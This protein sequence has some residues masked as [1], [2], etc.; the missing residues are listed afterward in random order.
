MPRP[1]LRRCWGRAGEAGAGEAPEVRGRRLRAQAGAPCQLP[2]RPRLRTTRLAPC[3]RHARGSSPVPGA[4]RALAGRARTRAGGERARRRRGRRGAAR[5]LSLVLTARLLRPRL[6]DLL[7]RPGGRLPQ[8]P[9][10]RPA[11]LR[12]LFPCFPGAPRFH[13]VGI[14]SQTEATAAGQ[15]CELGTSPFLWATQVLTF[16]MGPSSACEVGLRMEFNEGWG[17]GTP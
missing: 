14:W 12:L 3:E 17:P 4:G 11:G 8:A 1:R 13:S 6:C 9:A 7:P 2:L 5:E 15:Q 16:K 10:P